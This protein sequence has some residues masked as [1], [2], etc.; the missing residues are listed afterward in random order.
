MNMCQIETETAYLG[1]LI[2]SVGR[3]DRSLST[4]NRN[5]KDYLSVRYCKITMLYLKKKK[6]KNDDCLVIFTCGFIKQVLHTRI[7]LASSI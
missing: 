7:G 4:R 5:L 3:D 6:K 1:K 2:P